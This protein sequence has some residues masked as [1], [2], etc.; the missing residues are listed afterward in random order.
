[1][2]VRKE[3]QALTGSETCR[4]CTLG[5]APTELSILVSLLFGGGQGLDPCGL[6]QAEL[7]SLMSR[8]ITP[9]DY[10]MLLALDN[11]VSKEASELLSAADC[12]RLPGTDP[13]MNFE[14]EECAVCLGA[15]SD[16]DD[17]I[18]GLPCCKH[19][20]HRDCIVE[21]LTCFRAKCPLD[22]FDVVVA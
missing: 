12:D 16:A 7:R 6:T 20:F 9:E 10:D 3:A 17:A 22:N 4:R 5:L 19:V 13:A 18:C 14:G 2:R 8:D 15:M 1:M 21:W 11:D